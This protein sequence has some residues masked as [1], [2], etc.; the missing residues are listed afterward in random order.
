M[1]RPRLAELIAS[2]ALVTAGCTA[3]PPVAATTPTPSSPSAHPEQQGAARHINHHDAQRPIP[4]RRGERFLPLSAPGHYRPSAP[5]GG[6]DDYRCFL[7]DPGLSR[8]Q[9][10]TGVRFRPGNPKV[11]HHAILFAIP[12]MSAVSAWA[13][14]AAEPGPGWT[15][16]GG[17]R[18]PVDFADPMD[19][20]NAA[21]WLAGWARGTGEQLFPRGVGV[22]LERG[23]QIVLQVHYNLLDGHG[24]DR[25]G[26]RLRLAPGASDLEPV[27]TMLLPAPVELPC[28]P[29]ESGRLCHRPAAI[30][31]AELRFGEHS[32][33]A[34]AG[35]QLLCG[36]NPLIPFPGPTQSCDRTVTRPGTVVAAA[37]HMH[38][39]GRS[40]RIRLNPGR[41]SARTL[42]DIPTWNFD[43]Q[44][45]RPLPAP[46]RLQPG[47]VVR[48][49]CTHDAR[50][51]SQLPALAD[52]PPRYVVWGEGTSDEMCLG[53]LLVTRP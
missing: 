19:A 1:R 12:A 53:V 36:G 29:R 13:Q 33:A 18:V 4:L 34:V 42:L 27:Q 16:F 10:L 25:T 49:T 9:F 32:A 20:L 35:L 40:I 22:R 7:I 30:R 48:V 28:L 23:E 17:P 47:D 21:P 8:S 11:V 2:I 38:L 39:L 44:S 43:D 50:L 5:N 51:R 52:T 26:V 41:P 46:V 24:A 31:D 15:C 14:D 45:S 37:G 3:S 6:S